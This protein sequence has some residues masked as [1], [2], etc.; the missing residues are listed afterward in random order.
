LRN[1]TR[2][3]IQDSVTKTVARLQ[4][5][6]QGPDV[7]V[8]ERDF[9][10]VLKDHFHRIGQ[11]EIA[12]EVTDMLIGWTDQSYRPAEASFP[13]GG[14]SG[15]VMKNNTYKSKLVPDEQKAATEA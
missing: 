8:S 5:V 4:R 9:L 12:E 13:P 14:T 2:E 1:V 7:E 15:F 10:L 11:D 6:R 3:V